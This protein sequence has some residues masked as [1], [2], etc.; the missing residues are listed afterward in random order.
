MAIILTKQLSYTFIDETTPQVLEIGAA[1]REA[2]IA[3]MVADGKTNGIWSGDAFTSR[4]QFADQASA[5]EFLAASPSWNSGRTIV[6]S[7]ITDL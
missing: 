1:A 7:L 3:Q 2:F 5:E 4:W 6:S